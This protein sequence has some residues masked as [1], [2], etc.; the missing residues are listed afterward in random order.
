MQDSTVFP[1]QTGCLLCPLPTGHNPLR[2]SC[3]WADHF[4]T[5]D[6]NSHSWT[7]LDGRCISPPSD[8]YDDCLTRHPHMM[9]QQWVTCI[10]FS[11]DKTGNRVE[12]YS[13]NLYARR[14]FL[15]CSQAVRQSLAKH[16][17]SEQSRP[18][19]ILPDGAVP[20][21][22]P[23]LTLLICFGALVA[24]KRCFGDCP[25]GQRSSYGSHWTKRD[26]RHAMR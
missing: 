8:T 14:Q 1:R 7:L 20:T 12:A 2:P 13:R 11:R 17:L 19:D 3:G 23:L 9:N 15:T 6:S 25:W 16:S 10:L 4:K 22:T 5:W 26:E 24:D 21:R 18:V